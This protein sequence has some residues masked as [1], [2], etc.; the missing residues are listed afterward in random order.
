LLVCLAGCA[1][2]DTPRA[3]AS[4]KLTGV[5]PADA[6]P[7]TSETERARAAQEKQCAQR[8]LD[9]ING[10]LRE[11]AEQKRDR[12]EICAAYYRGS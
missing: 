4:V 12:D 10:T 8:H 11:T 9:R 7:V 6:K 2:E 3:T 5:R 1:C